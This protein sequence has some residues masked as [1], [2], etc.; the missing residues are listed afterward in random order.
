MTTSILHQITP[1]GANVDEDGVSFR[2]WA[3]QRSAVH[4]V[5]VTPDGQEQ[6]RI[7]LGRD[8]DGFFSARVA[9]AKDGDLYGY[10]VDDDPKLYPDPASHFQPQGVD[11]PSQVVDHRRFN[12]TDTDWPGAELLGQVVYELH[13]GTFTPEGT[14]AAAIEKLPHLRD[15]GVTLLEVMPVAAFPGKFGWGYDGV[16][17]YAP[18]QLYGTPDDFRNFVNAAHGHGI[19]VIL[20][21]VYNHFGPCGNCAGL[22]S[23]YYL[24]NGHTTEWGSAINFDGEQSVPVR[25]F[26][27]ESAAHWIRNYHLDGLRLDATHAMIDDSDEHIVSELTR[28]ARAAAG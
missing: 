4:V 24:S 2:V 22:F 19:G 12:W 26:V 3:P 11:G 17:W 1:A 16:F 28:A 7:P 21:V 10:Q 15:L 25:A 18:T 20:D 13:V 8:D 27:A 6:R 23:P 14:W 9:D 5:L